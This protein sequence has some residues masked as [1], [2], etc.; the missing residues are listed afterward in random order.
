MS[1]ILYELGGLDDCRYS[2]FSW[3][4]RLALAHKGLAA[5]H[6]P[7]RVS[8]KAAIAFSGQTKVPTL[9]DGDEAV[10]DQQFHERRGRVPTFAVG[11]PFRSRRSG[12]LGRPGL[13]FILEWIAAKARSAR[14]SAG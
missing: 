2:L 1:L 3:R 4:T 5:E 11:R 10:L 14:L 8:D 6:R 9:R 7:V 13:R 12:L